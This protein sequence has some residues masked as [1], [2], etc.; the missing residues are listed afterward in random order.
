M[1]DLIEAGYVYIAQPPLYQIK[2]AGAKGKEKIRY[3]MQ[4]GL[5]PGTGETKD[6]ADAP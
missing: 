4:R 2:P 5:A 6:D 1:R 3:A